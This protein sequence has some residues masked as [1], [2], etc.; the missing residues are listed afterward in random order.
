MV[1]VQHHMS[2]AYHPQTDGQSERTIQVLKEVLRTYVDPHQSD[3]DVWLPLA[4]FAV[5]NSWHESIQTTPFYL[6]HGAHPRTPLTVRMPVHAPEASEFVDHIQACVHR[7][8]EAMERAQ[9]RMARYANKSRRDVRYAVGDLVLLK[10]NHLHFKAKGARK[11][12]H[13]Y[14]GPFRVE[15]VYGTGGNSVRLALPQHGGWERIHP[16]FNVAQV[17]PYRARPGGTPEFCPP[18]LEVV[19]GQPVYEVEAIVG[20]KVL[21]KADPPL[22]SHYLV[23]WKGWPPEH[24]TYEPVEAVSGCRRLIDEYRQ[25][26][27]ITCGEVQ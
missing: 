13:K 21:P 2:T 16:T 4:Q 25:A 23:R 8:S 5:N 12:F 18:A 15:A 19:K 7:A 22:I 10:S 20:H 24:D 26:K 27:G 14:V 3:W 1:G 17:K 11:L 6:N 9:E